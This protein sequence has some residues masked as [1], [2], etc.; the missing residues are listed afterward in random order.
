[1]TCTVELTMK[2]AMRLME[3]MVASKVRNAIINT[4]GPMLKAALEE[5]KQ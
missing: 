4:R 1:V 3:P 2:G 5:G